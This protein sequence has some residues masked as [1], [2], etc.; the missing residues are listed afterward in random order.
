MLAGQFHPPTGPNL[1]SSCRS[2]FTCIGF[3][4]GTICLAIAVIVPCELA[5]VAATTDTTQED[6]NGANQHWSLQPVRQVELPEI[7]DPLWAASPMDRFI[8]VRIGE[9]QLVPAPLA[10][11]RT[12][13]RRATF[14]LWGLP[15]KPEAI[16]T[17]L[18]DAAGDQTAFANLVERLLASPQYGERWG[19]HWLDI[20]RYADTQGEVTDYPIPDAWK[21]RNWVINALNDD[22][23]YDQFIQ[24]QI[25]GDILAKDVEDPQQFQDLHHGTGL[26]ALARRFGNNRYLDHHLTIEDTI[27]TIG[28]GVLGITLR[29]ARC[30]DHKFDPVSTDDYYGLYGIFS[31]TRYPSMSSTDEQTPFNLAPL[32]RDEHVHQ[33]FDEY[34][35]L[36]DHYWQQIRNREKEFLKPTLDEFRVTTAAISAA[37]E[38]GEASEKLQQRREELLAAFDGSYREL[39]EHGLDW[40][41]D[42]KQELAKNPPCESVFAVSEGVVADCREHLRGDPKKLGDVVPRD[43][44]RSIV[45]PDRPVISESYGSGRL[46]LARWLTS[47][48]NPLTPRVIVNRVWHYRFGRGLVATPS[49]FGV[50]GQRPSHPDLLDYLASEFI[51]D[52]WSLKQLH[53]RMMASR[54]YR[55]ASLDVSANTE[56]DPNNIYL[57][58]HSRRRLEAEAIRDAMLTVSGELDT[59]PG[60]GHPFGPWY[61]WDYNLNRPFKA[62]YPSRRRSVYLMTQRLFTHPVLSLFD[63]ADTT[64]STAVRKSSHVP[65]QSLFLM[66]SPY[67]HE[68]AAAFSQRL[69]AASETGAARIELAYLW[70]LGRSPSAE[71]T[72]DV[73]DYVQRSRAKW[74]DRAASSQLDAE[75]R[76]WSGVARTLLSCN[77]FVFVD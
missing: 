18:T 29:C 70:A 43:V 30:H 20:A 53:R 73:I 48:K 55:L 12:L 11:R 38:N 2:A 69:I 32:S 72:A 64:Q 6:G 22:M 54:T 4:A 45:G 14:D 23:P 34:W 46:E 71:E 33:Q 9:Q 52:G 60:E 5:A 24:A 65:S 28:R 7:G 59:T 61:D 27:D 50:Q 44:P 25:A 63:Q 41:R 39:M 40:L 26:I 49:D 42:Q 1:I 68:R 74:Q 58:K 8:F 16:D 19:R 62:V 37:E 10:G 15:A 76:A 77:E 36:L 75:K 56:R 31:S 3:T 51:A 67:V 66:N 13:I 21:Y 35:R 47:P 57:W 17:F